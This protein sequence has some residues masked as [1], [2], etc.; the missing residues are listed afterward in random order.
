MNVVS[1][2]NMSNTE[3]AIEWRV[4]YCYRA[5]PKYLFP[6]ATLYFESIET[7]SDMFG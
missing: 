1:T 7:L 2:E 6:N 3:Q 5:S 4:G